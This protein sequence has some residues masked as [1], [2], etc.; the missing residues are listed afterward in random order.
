MSP[1]LKGLFFET[2]AFL[3]RHQ[4]NS[5]SLFIMNNNQGNKKSGEKHDAERHPDA[6]KKL[7]HYILS[8]RL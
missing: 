3:K 6:Q 5:K 7:K 8:N 4:Q 1:N 2:S